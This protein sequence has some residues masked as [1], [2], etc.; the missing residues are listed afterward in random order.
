MECDPTP[1]TLREHKDS[2]LHH[3][4]HQG[5]VGAGLS[6]L[7]PADILADPCDEGELGPLA[8]CIPSGEAHKSKQ[9]DVICTNSKRRARCSVRTPRSTPPGGA[10]NLKGA[11]CDT[12]GATIPSFGPNNS[13]AG[14][15]AHF[16]D[17]RQRR[18]RAPGRSAQ[19]GSLSDCHTCHPALPSNSHTSNSESDLGSKRLSTVFIPNL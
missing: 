11:Q 7:Q 4:L 18:T 10:V 3:L 8:H 1:Q 19:R 2:Y 17:G 6:A 13:A 16:I 15:D 9:S 5:L 14:G 12:E